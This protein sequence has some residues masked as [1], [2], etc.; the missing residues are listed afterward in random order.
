MNNSDSP[1]G[2]L[3]FLHWD[4]PWNNYK[5]P[6]KKSLKKAVRLMKEAGIS[7]VR[8]DF[9]WGDIEPQQGT[10]KFAKYDQIVE[11]VTAEGI[12][13]L[14]I[15]HYSADWA[16]SCGAWNCPPK[17]NKLFVNYAIN[18]ASRYKDKVKFWEIWNE[19]DSG[20]YWKP[21]D[22][23]KSYCI[24]LKDVYFALKKIDP[25]CIVLNGGLAEGIGSVN[26]LYDNGAKDY[27]DILNIHIFQS[28]LNQGAI[29]AVTSYPKIAYKVMKRNG[30]GNKKIWVTEIGCPGVRRGSR[31]ANWWMGENPD[32]AQQAEWVKHVY[33]GLLA[34]QSVAKVFWAFFRDCQGHWS[35]GVDYFGLIKWDYS[36]K[37]SFKAYRQVVDEYKKG[38]L[39]KGAPKDKLRGA[40]ID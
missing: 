10:F 23:L 19:P 6:D 5:Y 11:A 21:Q 31:T 20:T 22:G 30:D 32:E 38:I 40:R 34:D 9:L 4:H 7:W 13:I 26:R 17:D 36:K 27:F 14:G 39:F 35:N 29:H 3:E 25:G 16:S 12:S 1:F 2:V 18:V 8:L 28:P 15:L 24:L 33:K 37:P